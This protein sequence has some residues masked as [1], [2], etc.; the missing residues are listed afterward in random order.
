MASTNFVNG[1]VIVPDWLNDVNKTTYTIRDSGIFSI[2]EVCVGD[3]VTNDF[4]A[5]QQAITDYPGKVLD[6]GN[7]TYKINS[8]LTGLTSGQTLQ[9]MTLDFT[10]Y[11]GTLP[12]ISAAGTKGAAQNLTS[13][14]FNTSVVVNVASTA[15]FAA[16]Q[17]AWLQ[18][19]DVWST[20]DGTIFGQIVKVKTINSG[21]QLTLYAPPI[22][23]FNTSA[24]ASISPINPVNKIK[25]K[26]VN[27]I[28]VGTGIQTAIRINYGLDCVV[29]NTCKITD[30]DYAGVVYYRCINSQAAPIALRAR[31]FGLAYGVV[32]A[33][34][35]KSVAVDNGYGEDIR[36][37]VTI[38][39]NEGIN[40]HCRATNNFINYARSAGI[41]SHNASFDFIASGNQI[42]LATGGDGDG[43]TLQ[44]I[45]NQ[46]VN[47][48]IRNVE[49]VG[50]MLQPLVTTS[51][52]K[53]SATA[54]GNYVYLAN[55]ATTSQVA[56]N[57]VVNNVTGTDFESVNIENNIVFGGTGGLSVIHYYVY[58]IKPSSKI[59]N[60]N[61]NNN[62]SVHPALNQCC[63]VRALGDASTVEN[64]NITGNIFKTTGVRNIALL[65]EGSAVP[66]T[67]R[68]LVSK[69]IIANN[70]IDG[71]SIAGL[72]I[73]ADPGIISSV[74]EDNNIFTNVTALYETNG[75]ALT[76]VVL[77]TSNFTL[78]T[79]V[80][81][82]SASATPDANWY[83]FNNGATVTF[84]LPEAT[85]FPNRTLRLRTIQAFAVNSAT[86]NVI[87]RTGG[88]AGSAILP[89]TDGAWADVRS[90]G[91]NW[92]IIASS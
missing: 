35:C 1:T 81:A 66:P 18:S 91:T 50:I 34:G 65:S 92:E 31:A 32:I 23:N 54:R 51:Q 61:I 76:G 12:F 8:V 89:A 21:T 72:S 39:D 44:G 41:D 28:G 68:G 22:V 15:S 5:F 78:A 25:F 58:T 48:T 42:V 9:N 74:V 80:T 67:S 77:K 46:A 7:K 63:L 14:L 13:N 82:G 4:T 55:N 75:S 84:T 19:T 79:T 45:N 53:N 71:G 3:G 52:I 87:P 90:N 88:A 57:A 60:V 70:N 83:I 2:P 85:V 33:G 17:W 40:I 38:G 26:N 64:I 16:E 29:E 10:G 73:F 24:S 59:S 56:I 86:S 47:N 20:I 69:T 27:I 49:G 11:A 6:G 37:Y 36:H 62:I 30:V 43:I